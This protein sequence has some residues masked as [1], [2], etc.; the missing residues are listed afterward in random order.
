MFQN[1]EQS[2]VVNGLEWIFG[3][4]R[5][6]KSWM[7]KATDPVLELLSEDFVLNARSLWYTLRNRADESGDAPGRNTV[8]RA[9]E[10]LEKHGFVNALDENDSYYVITQ[11]GER[12]LEGE[13]V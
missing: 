6:R 1:V 13:T 11:K 7:N 9:L 4:M 3:P 2:A 12:Y 10:K 8:Y 5:D